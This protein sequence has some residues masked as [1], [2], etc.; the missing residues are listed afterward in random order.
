MEP[1]ETAEELTGRESGVWKVQTHRSEY[2]FDFDEHTVTR[3]PGVDAGSTINDGTRPLRRIEIC[4]V[5]E[6]GRWTMLSDEFETDYYWQ[7]SSAV[8]RIEKL[9]SA[10]EEVIGESR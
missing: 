8:T 10:G 9:S 1:T 7:V 6:R 3:I 5:G 2:V 4:L